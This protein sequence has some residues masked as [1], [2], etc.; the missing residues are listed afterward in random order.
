M[1]RH[2][3]H[4]LSN[5]LCADGQVTKNETWSPSR[6]LSRQC[7]CLS[8]A[9]DGSVVSFVHR[10]AVTS[11]AESPGIKTLIDEDFVTLR[12]CDHKVQPVNAPSEQSVHPAC[13]D[14]STQPGAVM[15]RR[16]VSSEVLYCSCRSSLL[17]SIQTSCLPAGSSAAHLTAEDNEQ[18]G[19][20]QSPPTAIRTSENCP[21]AP[22]LSHMRGTRGSLRLFE[23]LR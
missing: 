22:E 1:F 4:T 14:G 7:T 13:S 6:L 9:A 21:R 10:P 8:Q 12:C 18:N 15:F 19:K 5:C 20:N 11:G 23:H 16:G 2:T 3:I 17:T